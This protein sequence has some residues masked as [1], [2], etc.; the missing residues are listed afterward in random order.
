MSNH[1]APTVGINMLFDAG[2]LADVGRPRAARTAAAHPGG[3]QGAG[4]RRRCDDPPEDVHRRGGVRIAPRPNQLAILTGGLAQ[5]H[6]GQLRHELEHDAARMSTIITQLLKLS[7]W[8]AADPLLDKVELNTLVRDICIAYAPMALD[9]GKSLELDEQDRIWVEA[10]PEILR[11]AIS[12]L[13]ENALMHTSLGSSVDLAVSTSG[14]LVVYNHGASVPDENWPEL[15]KP[16]FKAPLN[17]PGAGWALP[18]SR[19]PWRPRGH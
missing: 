10:N 14:T 18:S 19:K 2:M 5:L 16:F 4:T 9:A 3:Q 8:R 6:Q 1:A 12:K 11:I 13:V 15:F 7:S 17:K